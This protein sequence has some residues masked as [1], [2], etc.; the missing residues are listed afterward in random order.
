MGRILAVE[1]SS[2]LRR[3]ADCT[4][5]SWHLD[6][7]ISFKLHLSLPNTRWSTT[8]AIEQVLNLVIGSGVAEKSL[9]G[10]WQSRARKPLSSN[11]P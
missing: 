11:D 5:S 7:T 6:C 8:M 1:N 4:K 9:P 10:P 2:W 3:H